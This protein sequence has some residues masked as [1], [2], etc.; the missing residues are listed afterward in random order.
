MEFA[1]KFGPWALVTGASSGIG[2]EFCLQL[3]KLGL[4]LVLVARSQGK[5]EDVSRYIED[6]YGV[7]TRVIALDLSVPGASDIL[8]VRTNHMDIGLLVSNAGFASPGRY[9]N[10]HLDKVRSTVQL[11]V[12]AHTELVHYFGQRIIERRKG[13][14]GVILLSSTVAMQGLPFLAIYSAA[15][16]YILSFGEAFHYENVSRGLHVS[17][18][19]AGA[20]ATPML[21][22]DNPKAHKALSSFFVPVMTPE[23]VVKGSIKAIERNKAVYIPGARNRFMVGFIGRRLLSRKANIAFWASVFGRYHKTFILPLLGRSD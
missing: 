16:A 8:F 18:I 1:Q 5:L 3:A 11:N 22:I 12:S 20:T 21:E 19:A 15:K 23:R 13:K 14:G 2:Y 10:T 9:L 7:E 17:V 6:N 4:N